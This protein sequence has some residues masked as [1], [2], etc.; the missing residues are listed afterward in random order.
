LSKTKTCWDD[1]IAL[2]FEY[3]YSGV[4]VL[5]LAKKPTPSWAVG[6]HFQRQACQVG[7]NS[8]LRLV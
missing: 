1:A 4:R 8:I 2:E 6:V 7:L 3:L 5:V